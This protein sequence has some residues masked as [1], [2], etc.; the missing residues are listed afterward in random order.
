MGAGKSWSDEF[1]IKISPHPNPLSRFFLWEREGTIERFFMS[2][3]FISS[4]SNPILIDMPL[5]IRTSRLLIRSVI[6]GDGLAIRD[7]YAE[8]W[9][10][11]SKW[12]DWTIYGLDSVEELELH[13]RQ[14]QAKFIL[15][16][17]FVFCVFEQATEKMIATCNVTCSDWDFRT[18]E[19]GYLVRTS[20]CNKGYA[21]EIANALARYVFLVLG[22]QRVELKAITENSASRKVIEKCGFTLEC[23]KK[24][25]LHLP[26][27]NIAGHA[28][29]VCYD[30]AD[31]SDLKVSWGNE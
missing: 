20:E 21:T 11:L 8:S 3:K 5:P 18:F 25:D 1:D 30:V 23:I 10:E 14:N 27:G 17:K 28:E 12:V 9:D 6:A 13:C 31:L 16:E 26:N 15:R 7:M 4:N 29:Y 22:A 2:V 19:I 24:A